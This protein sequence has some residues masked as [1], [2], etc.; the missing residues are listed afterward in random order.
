LE[1]DILDINILAEIEK[2]N[3]DILLEED[4]ILDIDILVEI[5]KTTKK[6][7]WRYS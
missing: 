7:I 6:K 2:D 4:D 3:K 1:K 5:E